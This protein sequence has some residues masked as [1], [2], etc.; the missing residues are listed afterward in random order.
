ML[1]MR[2]NKI[3]KPSSSPLKKP[4]ASEP[5][6]GG[7]WAQAARRARAENANPTQKRLRRPMS[8]IVTPFLIDAHCCCRHLKVMDAAP[9]GD[10]MLDNCL[11]MVA[12]N[13]LPL[14]IK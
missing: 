9:T 5:D 1:P 14:T 2:L 13:L 3:V 12:Q 10:H 4:G 6:G 11:P 8:V 7:W